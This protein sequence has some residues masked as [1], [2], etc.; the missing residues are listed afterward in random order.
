[1]YLNLAMAIFWWI[2][3]AILF[4]ARILGS[5]IKGMFPDSDLLFGV[6]AT[7]FAAY[8]FVRWWSARVRQKA[9][10][11]AAA[12]PPKKRPVER[13]VEYNPEF[14]FTRPDTP[15]DGRT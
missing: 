3:A 1:M 9:R 4:G 11:A 12:Q 8:K 15:P 13:P 6:A 2:I 5:P 10:E 7:V 14:D